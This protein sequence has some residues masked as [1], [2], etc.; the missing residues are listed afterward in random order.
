MNYS[1]AVITLLLLFAGSAPS[2]SQYF[3]KL[4]ISLDTRFMADIPII[5]AD[6]NEPGLSGELLA[7][8]YPGRQIPT[9]AIELSFPEMNGATD[10]LAILW[11]LKPEE[12]T[13]VEGE[14]NVIVAGFF[15]D[16]VIRYYI[17]S[18]NDRIFSRS[19]ASFVFRSDEK[20]RLL[21]ILIAG[22]YNEYTLMNPN[23]IVPVTP[24][25]AIKASKSRWVTTS[26]KPSVAIDISS[27]FGRGDANLSFAKTVRPSNT[28]TYFADIPGSF[29][30]SLAIDFSWFNFHLLISGGYERIEYTNNII[31]SIDGDN[32]TTYYN[33]GTWPNSKVFASLAF[34]YDISA[35]RYLY[36]TP[37]GSLSLFRN[38]TRYDFDSWQGA[39]PEA[40]YTDMHASE[41]GA[42]VKLPVS[43]SLIIYVNLA[44]A[45]VYYNAEQFFT[46]VVP[47]SYRMHQ[48]GFYYG[49][50][51]NFRITGR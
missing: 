31:V 15:P 12:I 41:F 6:P 38:D 14:I 22:S 13:A 17:D 46:D 43:P 20:H 26:R 48:D 29:R 37:Y 27:S 18:N 11:Y 16:N 25:D 50:G 35:G 23:Y 30:P 9:D 47:G 33:R 19:E 4:G 42:K 7:S 32:S 8:Q 2:F 24:S 10:T 1:K 3:T 44:Y 36:L 49:V 39:P 34:E 40:E 51:F 28:I 21:R 5:V 45:T